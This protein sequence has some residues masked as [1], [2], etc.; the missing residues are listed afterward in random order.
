MGTNHLQPHYCVLSVF[1]KSRGA[2]L[3]GWVEGSTCFL[4]RNLKTRKQSNLEE[5]NCSFIFEKS[6]KIDDK[7]TNK[8]RNKCVSWFKENYDWISWIWITTCEVIQIRLLLASKTRNLC[9]KGTA[10]LNSTMASLLSCGLSLF[11]LRGDPCKKSQVL[12]VAYGGLRSRVFPDL[13]SY[14]SIHKLK[15]L[16]RCIHS[17][18]RYSCENLLMTNCRW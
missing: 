3:H 17:Q 16:D 4:V 8:W 1:D 9:S 12:S 10:E 11:V 15:F 6:I 18:K 5:T 7:S 14:L 13:W 2:Y